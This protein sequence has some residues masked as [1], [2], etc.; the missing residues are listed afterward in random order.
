MAAPANL[1]VTGPLAQND[2]LK[3]VL[4]G[5]CQQFIDDNID[6]NNEILTKIKT[7]IKFA[8]YVFEPAKYA[9]YKEITPENEQ[10]W[11]MLPVQM[12]Q[13]W[14]PNEVSDMLTYAQLQTAYVKMR[15]ALIPQ[16]QHFLA[17][18]KSEAGSSVEAT[19]L[20]TWPKVIQ[21]VQEDPK[22]PLAY[23]DVKLKLTIEKVD[24]VT[25]TPIDPIKG[26]ITCTLVDSA[27]A[28]RV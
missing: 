3:N 13:G 1:R 28:D 27:F 25:N 22:G 21:I 24:R 26:T 16:Y 7:K 2:V 6:P 11:T 14:V 15:Q 10:T 17:H 8:P 20:S 23:V 9:C 12:P 5:P 18:Q 19:L 4:F